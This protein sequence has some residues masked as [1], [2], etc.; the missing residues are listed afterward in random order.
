MIDLSWIRVLLQRQD[1]DPRKGRSAVLV[2]DMP[3]G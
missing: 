3:V 2:H 1:A